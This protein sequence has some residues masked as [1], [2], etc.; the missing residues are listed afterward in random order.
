MTDTTS[1]VFGGKWTAASPRP[2]GGKRGLRR[3][4]H[5]TWSDISMSTSSFL[6]PIQTRLPLSCCAMLARSLSV[7]LP[8]SCES[9][10]KERAAHLC[11][12]TPNQCVRRLQGCARVPA[13]GRRA[14]KS[15]ANFAQVTHA[16]FGGLSSSDKPVQRLR[17][18]KAST[19]CSPVEMLGMWMVVLK[20]SSISISCSTSFLLVVPM[21]SSFLP[22]GRRERKQRVPVTRS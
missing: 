14:L 6:M 12:H 22:C 21:M 8:S 16:A 15:A 1:F 7:K 5:R 13:C 9:K 4:P 19:S 17:T 10:G 2:R 18:S 11:L 20:A 3:W